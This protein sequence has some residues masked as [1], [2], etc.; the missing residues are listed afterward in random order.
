MG[1]SGL[2]A[3]LF[4]D[5]ATASEQPWLLTLMAQRRAGTGEKRMVSLMFNYPMPTSSMMS[6]RRGDF[7]AVTTSGNSSTPWTE[8]SAVGQS[9]LAVPADVVAAARTS[10]Q[11]ALA[12]QLL[13]RTTDNGMLEISSPTTPRRVYNVPVFDSQFVLT[14][15]TLDPDPT[16]IRS[17]FSL[18]L[19]PGSQ[20]PV[21]PVMPGT[22]SGPQYSAAATWGIAI[23]LA[24]VGLLLGLLLAWI[25]GMGRNNTATGPSAIVTTTPPGYPPGYPAAGYPAGYPAAGYVLPPG[26]PAVNPVGTPYQ[27]SSRVSQQPALASQQVAQGAPN[28]PSTYFS[29]TNAPPYTWPS[30]STAKA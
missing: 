2:G 4:L 1:E 21:C 28:A 9:S 7:Y 24:I 27:S 22:G 10:G 11:V 3:T 23:G 6:S 15:A 17:A 29:S 25:F 26:Y 16:H 13:F 12:Q 19:G 20:C 5:L 8:M 30:Q 14:A 18:P